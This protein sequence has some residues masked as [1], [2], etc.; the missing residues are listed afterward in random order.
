M[1]RASTYSDVIGSPQTRCTTCRTVF[2]VS[3]ELLSSS[4]TRVRCGECLSIFDALANLRTGDD[5]VDASVDASEVADQE[6]SDIDANDPAVD[7]VDTSLDLGDALSPYD[8]VAYAPTRTAYGDVES[9]D[10][11]YADFDLFSGEAELPE[12]AYLDQTSDT[13]EFDF[14]SVEIDQDETFSDTLF[15]QDATIDVALAARTSTSGADL[16]SRIDAAEAAFDDPEFLTDDT[17][18]EPIDFNYHD[19]TA[20][21]AIAGEAHIAGSGAGLDT[22]L[23]IDPEDAAAAVLE[24]DVDPD[25]THDATLDGAA[26]TS[27]SDSVV[28]PD[29]AQA[30]GVLRRTL[31]LLLVL[32]F[33][34]L[35][36]GLYVLRHRDTLHNEPLAR[37][38]LVPL[39]GVLD[40]VVPSRVDLASLELLK[41]DV[42]SHPDIADA[43]VI[44]V[45]FRN[46]ADFAQRYP[47][48]VVR[49]RDRVGR[50]VAE[51]DFQPNDYLDSWEPGDTLD[52]R[53]RLDIKLDV[54]DPGNDSESFEFEF[55]TAAE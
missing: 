17:I 34:V 28:A 35:I 26:D 53:Q 8:D 30:P 1:A 2:E 42:S 21:E 39:C 4:D 6:G 19:A 37:H 9:L 13:P 7:A 18:V 54:N 46:D 12:V 36:V 52:S 41:R 10:V 20:G 11:T 33:G 47:V 43:L 50:L 27:R 22:G 15:A 25:A 16:I 49:L 40:C 3:A 29:S 38:V 55:R 14:D 44:S 24:D 23:D 45:G 48:L 32:L 31:P 51:R 5:T